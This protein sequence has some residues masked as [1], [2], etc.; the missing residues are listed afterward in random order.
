MARVQRIEKDFRHEEHPLEQDSQEQ[1]IQ[2]EN[3]EV[4]EALDE[5]GRKE[6]ESIRRALDRM[7]SGEYGTCASCEEPIAPM[8]LRALPAAELCIRCAERLERE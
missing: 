5:S 7:E 6:L 4:L 3:D 8:R 2:L 1:S